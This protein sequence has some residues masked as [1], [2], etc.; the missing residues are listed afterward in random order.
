MIYVQIIF[1]IEFL[2]GAVCAMV[3]KWDTGMLMY[4]LGAAILNAGV[5][6][7]LLRR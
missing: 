3:P 1:V 6:I 4:Y 5:L 7:K 2:I